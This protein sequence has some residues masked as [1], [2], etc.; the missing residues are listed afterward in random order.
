MTRRYQ[1]FICEHL[2]RML[3]CFPNGGPSTPLS[4]EIYI[5]TLIEAVIEQDPTP[6]VLE[7]ACRHLVRNSIFFPTIAEVLQAVREQQR[8]ERAR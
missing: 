2:S 8:T 6:A 1:S 3:A 5:R 4:A 7:A